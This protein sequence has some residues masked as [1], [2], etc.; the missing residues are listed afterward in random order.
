M[1]DRK[2]FLEKLL[3][4]ASEKGY[5]LYDDL[6]NAADEAGLSIS[7]FDWLSR[8]ITLRGITLSEIA[9]SNK[10]AFEEL[11][12]KRM[13]LKWIELQN[14]RQF[15]NVHVDFAEGNDGKNVTIII[16]QNGA[17]KS[18]IEQAFFWCLYSKTSFTDPIM[19]NRDVQESMPPGKAESVKVEL[20]L[21]HKGTEYRLTRELDYTKDYSGT[22]KAAKE[23][24]FN[25][26]FRAEDGT[27]KYI[28]PDLQQAEVE[29][30]MPQSLSQYFFFDGERIEQMAKEITGNDQNDDFK[31]AV[32]G[33]LGLGGIM[34][35]IRHFKEVRSGKNTVIG[36]YNN[37]FTKENVALEQVLQQIEE[38]ER[39]LADIQDELNLYDSEISKAEVELERYRNDIT[40]YEKW[41]EILEVV[42]GYDSD[43]S[44]AEAAKHKAIAEATRLFRRD[45]SSF[46]SLSLINRAANF[47]DSQNLADANLPGV[48]KET[49][50]YLIANKK[51]LCGR[52]II[53]GTETYD[54]LQHLYDFLLPKSS[55][56][57]AKEFK[58]ECLKRIE[59]SG[60]MYE[61]IKLKVYA[62]QEQEKIREQKQ[63]V[64]DRFTESPIVQDNINDKFCQI[65][66]Q[67]S[68]CEMIIS[69]SR[70][71]RDRLKALQKSLRKDLRNYKVKL[72]D[73][74]SRDEQNRKTVIYLAYANR[75]YEELITE[76]TAEEAAVKTNLQDTIN[77]IFDDIYKDELHLEIKDN[78]KISV[79]DTRYESGVETSQGQSQAII[80][81]FILSL[82]K[83]KKEVMEKEGAQGDIYPLVLNAPL[84]LFDKTRIDAVCRKIPQIAEQVVIFI[85]DTDEEFIKEKMAGHIGK[86]YYFEKRSEFDS[87]FALNKSI[88]Y[89]R[90]AGF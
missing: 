73:I 23:A 63:K 76:Y 25:I 49:I 87:R 71:K 33:M 81:A 37:Q 19:L 57:I 72:T 83:I 67:I 61:D 1:P 70:K 62:V 34:N 74:S 86:Q 10:K 80:L 56:A 13:L 43:I 12:H 8:E 35:A 11:V 42:D 54:H 53:P 52:E 55:A 17:G 50:D 21:Y 68:C 41:K 36:Y 20:C 66:K 85:K 30:I 79:R 69:E 58:S 32:R 31:I 48:R 46:L 18:T 26:A 90:T 82:I 39:K 22:V 60:D 29:D 15:K 3:K 59:S 44:N 7:D 4:L 24:R 89:S 64:R 9:P 28:E 40:A 78:Y 75:I 38:N 84:S 51:C 27:T 16:G 77:H 47:I 65:K 88:S 2:S 6:S 45:L 5:L 14:F